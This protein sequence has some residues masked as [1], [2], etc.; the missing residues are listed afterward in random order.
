M[1]EKQ[2]KGKD[3]TKGKDSRHNQRRE[4]T[5]HIFDVFLTQSV[6]GGAVSAAVQ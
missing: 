4:E 3:E 2:T 1:R 5:L 6:Q